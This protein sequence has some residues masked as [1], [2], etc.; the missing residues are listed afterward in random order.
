MT[1]PEIIAFLDRGGP[2]MWAI[3]ALSVLLMALVLWKL[4]D[5]LRLGLWARAKANRAV[6]AWVAGQQPKL[7]G[8]GL[9]GAVVAQA[10]ALR[11]ANAP[12]AREETARIAK[13]GLARA[14]AGLRALD[15]IATIAPL[16]GLLGTVLGMIEA[17][18]ALQEAGARSDPAGLAGGFWHALLTTA[19][20]MAVAI[21]AS[22]AL[23]WFDGLV[24][25]L[26]ADLEDMAT[27]IFTAPVPGGR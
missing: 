20:G 2:A 17:F 11:L 12:E 8:G 7:R 23:A 18:Q 13:Q 27:R 14:R 10:M 16:I 22:V 5:L 3:A 15:L 6:Q 26:Q 19:A 9:R 4:F 24:E 25:G 1:N 21:P